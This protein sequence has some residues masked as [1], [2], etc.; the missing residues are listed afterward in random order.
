MH[1][2]LLFYQLCSHI[3][4]LYFVTSKTLAGFLLILQRFVFIF[5]HHTLDTMH[6]HLTGLWRTG[7]CLC[8][9]G[10]PIL[11]ELFTLHMLFFSALNYDLANQS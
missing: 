7:K 9:Y 1:H 5:C 8:Q 10:F 11:L 3:L 6:Y 2:A 4:F